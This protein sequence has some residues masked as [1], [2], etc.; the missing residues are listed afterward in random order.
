MLAPARW[1]GS[2]ALLAVTKSSKIRSKTRPPPPETAKPE[3][4]P[5]RNSRCKTEKAL[6]PYH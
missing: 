4:G 2:E 6:T 3:N 1:M 5:P